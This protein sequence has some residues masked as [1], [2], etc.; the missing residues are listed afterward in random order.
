MQKVRSYGRATRPMGE[1]ISTEEKHIC[2]EIFN[3]DTTLSKFEFINKIKIPVCFS[4]YSQVEFSF[5]SIEAVFTG[6]SSFLKIGETKRHVNWF[7][8]IRY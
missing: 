4:F 6:V 8:I 1:K 2:R 5:S 7:I 3:L